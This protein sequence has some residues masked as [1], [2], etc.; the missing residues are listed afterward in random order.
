MSCQ[1]ESHPL[2]HFCCAKFILNWEERKKHTALLR[3]RLYA[4]LKLGS[5]GVLWDA[6]IVQEVVKVV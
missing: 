6:V 5:F 1:P 4:V 3:V 2:L